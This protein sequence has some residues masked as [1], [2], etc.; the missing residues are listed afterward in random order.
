MSNISSN[1]LFHFTPKKEY[2]I[3]ILKQTF[4]PRYKFEEIKLSYKLKRP[5]FESAIPMVCF[6][7]LSL[8]Q[9]IR[10]VEM[11]GSY[12][13]GMTK[14][15]GIR[16]KL[17]PIIYV[18]PNSNISESVSQMA[19]NVY[20]A[21]D[22]HCSQITL[23]LSDEYMNLTNFLK[24]YEGDFKRGNDKHENVRFYNEREWRYVPKIEFDSE[25]KNNLSRD[26]F[27]NPTILE[28]ENKKLIDFRLGFKPNDIKYIFVKN[29]E[30]IHPVM[31]EL[32]NIKS[33]FSRKE[34][35]VLT[36]KIITTEQIKQDF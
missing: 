18:N 35:D 11:Y 23:D 17:N 21:L 1:S 6:C 36:S 29:E 9:I 7:D 28:N 14:E 12:G 16:K 22:K 20:Q 19:E 13:L 34:I 5:G 15:W 3:S 33:R 32:R 10:H 30:E 8:S 2:L 27:S 26:E 31:E 25:V 4:V 24:P